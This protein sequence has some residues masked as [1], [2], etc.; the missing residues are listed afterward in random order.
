MRKIISYQILI[1]IMLGVLW[2][3]GPLGNIPLWLKEYELVINCILVSTL[4]G[5]LYCLRAIYVNYSVH[6]NWDA[7][8]EVWYYL[9]PIASSICGLIAY[10]FLKASI[11]ILEADQ[12]ENAGNY[13]YLAFAFIAG[14]NVDKFLKKIEGLAKSSFGVEKSRASRQGENDD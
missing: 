14:F 6:K 5:V 2:A 3:Q 12:T 11:I 8:W 13:G 7:Y 1:L 10:I 9:R 4:A